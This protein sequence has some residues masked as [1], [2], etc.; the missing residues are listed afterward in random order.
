M[1]P[2]NS[3]ANQFKM[4]NKDN[5]ASLDSNGS[6]DHRIISKDNLINFI[7]K[8]SLI[9]LDKW[10][11]INKDSHKILIISNLLIKSTKIH[12][13]KANNL[14]TKRRKPK[15]KRKR[16]RKKIRKSKNKNR[17][18]N[19][20]RKRNKSRKRRKSKEE[21]IRNQILMCKLLFKQEFLKKLLRI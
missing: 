12:H 6:K 3:K 17:N 1:H 18:K 20:N 5:K 4:F 14:P 10:F 7:N 15:K 8:D 2:I 21:V 9:S 16:K 19:R 11:Q 13:K